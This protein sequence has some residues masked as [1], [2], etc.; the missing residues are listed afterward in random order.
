MWCIGNTVVRKHRFTLKGACI[1]KDKLATMPPSDE[2]S[3]EE[4]GRV[5]GQAEE[6]YSKYSGQGRFSH[7]NDTEKWPEQSEG[8]SNATLHGENIPSKENSDPVH[9]RGNADTFF[10]CKLG[11]LSMFLGIWRSLKRFSIFLFILIT[12][13]SCRWGHLGDSAV[14]RLPSAQGMIQVQERV[15]HQAPCE[16]PASV[17]AY[18]SASLSVSLML[19]FS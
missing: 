13:I 17:S 11:S 15:P 6:S 14:E 19:S 8:V 2:H 5:R 3:E 9:S 7:G 10:F 12:L 18:V 1:H 4:Q 16:E